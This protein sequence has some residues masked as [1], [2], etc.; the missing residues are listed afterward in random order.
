MLKIYLLTLFA[1][2]SLQPPIIYQTAEPRTV[3]DYYRL[4][5]DKYFEADEEQRVNW[6]LDPKRGAVVDVKNGYIY[7]PGDGAQNTLYVCLFRKADSSYVI[8]VKAD[9]EGST[10][11]DFYEYRGG[12]FVDVTKSVLPVAVDENLEYEMPRY[13]TTIKV[14]DRTGKSLYNL[15]WGRGRFGKTKA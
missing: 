6:M 4:L 8:A 5:P 10:Q 7:A 15:A 3:L 1:S 9:V 14:K 2:L 11:L 12:S 13:G